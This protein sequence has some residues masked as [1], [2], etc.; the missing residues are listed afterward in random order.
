MEVLQIEERIV[1]N[2]IRVLR[3]NG[4]IYSPRSGF[5]KPASGSTAL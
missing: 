3:E 2:E 4:L 5:L 1:R